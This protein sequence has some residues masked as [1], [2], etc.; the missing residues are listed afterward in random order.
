MDSV[1]CAVNLYVLQFMVF[2]ASGNSVITRSSGREGGKC[3]AS[4]SEKTLA[5]FWN[6]SGTATLLCPFPSHCAH[7]WLKL[8]LHTFVLRAAHFNLGFRV[9]APRAK[10]AGRPERELLEE[11][12]ISGG[13]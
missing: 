2:G 10:R 3:F 9:G 5:Y 11:T 1:S 4:S 8:V 7:C 6:C 13:E 12:R